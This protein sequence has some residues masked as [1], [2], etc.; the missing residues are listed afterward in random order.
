MEELPVWLSSLAAMGYILMRIVLAELVWFSEG[1]ACKLKV[2]MVQ[3]TVAVDVMVATTM[4]L[5]LLVEE[6]VAGKSMVM[7]TASQLLM[8]QSAIGKPLPL[9]LVLDLLVEA[10]NVSSA[11]LVPMMEELTA[12]ALTMVELG[13]SVEEVVA[14]KLLARLFLSAE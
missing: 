1:V 14:S 3:E 12:I 10:A 4:E 7:V 8:E 2:P 5:G 6:V 9:R 13:F 11:W